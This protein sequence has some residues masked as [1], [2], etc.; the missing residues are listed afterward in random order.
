M[1]VLNFTIDEFIIKWEKG[2]HGE[3]LPLKGISCP[4]NFFCFL[5]T[6]K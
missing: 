6:I 2:I 3:C 4:Q 5:A 1:R